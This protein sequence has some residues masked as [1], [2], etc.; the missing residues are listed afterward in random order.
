MS[1]SRKAAVLNRRYQ[2][3][4]AAA[5]KGAGL[6]RFAQSWLGCSWYGER[7]SDPT[8]QKTGEFENSINPDTQFWRKALKDETTAGGFKKVSRSE[9]VELLNQDLSR[10]YQAI[11]GV[12]RLF[13]GF[14]KR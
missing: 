6:F 13:T 2:G 12:C 10:E 1:G 11:I 14:E 7:D 3:L 9:L 5:S 4:C 8:H